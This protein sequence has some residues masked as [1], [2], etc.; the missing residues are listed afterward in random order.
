MQTSKLVA[1][2]FSLLLAACSGDDEAV[3]EQIDYSTYGTAA[4]QALFDAGEFQEVFTIVRAQ[5][6]LKIADKDDFLILTDV[7][8]VLLNGVSA[9]VALEK[10]KEEDATDQEITLRLARA[11]MLQTRYDDALATIGSVVLTGNDAFEA[12]LLRG[13]I[14]R[15]LNEVERARFFYEEAV[16][17][18]PE[19]FKGYLGLALLELR[20]G[21][22]KE[23]ENYSLQA[24]K[25]TDDDAIVRYVRG[26]AAR[27]LLQTDVA[28]E[29]LEKAVELHPAHIQANLE[30]AGIYIDKRDFETAQKYL[31]F[32][33]SIVPEHPQAR[34]HSALI[35]ATEGKTK[36]AEELLLR[37]GDFTRE[38]PPASRVYGHVAFQLGK[39]TAAQPHLERFLKMVPE[40][41]IT[42]L[43]LAESMARRGEPEAALMR[44]EPLIGEESV[45]LEAY[46]QAAS[47]AGIAGDMLKARDYIARAKEIA[48]NSEEADEGLLKALGKRL[49]LTRFMTGDL[50]RAVE[51]LRAMYGEDPS[52]FTSLTLLANLQMEGGDIS[53]AK[54]TVLQILEIE[55]EKPITANLLGAVLFRQGEVD[56][57]IASFSEAI[58]RNPD[59]ISAL[60]NR[61]LAYVRTRQY[62]KALPD[63]VRV[64]QA[65]P[66]DSHV[67]GMLGR[68]YLELGDTDKAIEY[69][70]SAEAAFPQSALIL[71]DHSEAL[72]Q[73]G[74]MQSA[75]SKAKTAKQ[76]AGGNEGLVQYLT[77][78]IAGWE[79]KE[80]ERKALL[81]EEEAEAR[82]AYLK[83]K[84]AKEKELEERRAKNAAAEAESLAGQVEEKEPEETEEDDPPIAL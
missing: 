36:E 40:D 78:T 80:A 73:K 17:D 61:G 74:F 62:D 30:L 1:L 35:L 28:I 46:M 41:R 54:E 18:Q 75:I 60:K 57:A 49:A 82:A 12:L 15:E 45:D 48:E 66:Q 37:I 10:A 22:L 27:Y 63:L 59:Y 81:A 84:A 38:F 79:Q 53:G 5:D 34:Y 69:L 50:E 47:A 29:H 76:Y 44:L 20:L 83:E 56:S 21:N 19:Q 71:S 23:A 25:Y 11:Y 51:Q 24:S 31:D 39:F 7:F 3:E 70:Q 26:T 72:A 64:L 58:R 65:V 43:A 13:D 2:T 9:E 68:T 52:D 42:R 6:A 32:V 4:V 14:H 33:Y 77:E 67:H 16:K 8:L 55:P